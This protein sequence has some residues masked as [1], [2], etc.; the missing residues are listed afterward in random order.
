[1]NGNELLK[2]LRKLARERHEQLI[3]L[4]TRGKGLLKTM[5][6]DL[7]LTLSDIEGL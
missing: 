3:I 7:G 5:L 4:N 6:S 2:K 1:M